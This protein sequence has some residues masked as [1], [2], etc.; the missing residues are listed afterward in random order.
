MFHKCSH[1]CIPNIVTFY[2]AHLYDS[3]PVHHESLG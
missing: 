1:Y 3:H 2:K